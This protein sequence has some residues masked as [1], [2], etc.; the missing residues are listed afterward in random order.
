MTAPTPDDL[1]TPDAVAQWLGQD[2]PEQHIETVIPA[3][4]AYVREIHGD[5]ELSEPV[6]LGALMLAAL[7][8]RRRNSPGG[9]EAFGDLDPAFVARY[10]PTISQLLQLG[11]YRRLV[12]G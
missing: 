9:V 10:D 3:V 2:T 11:N 5:G 12:V 8:V 1:L 7:I 6:K 4:T